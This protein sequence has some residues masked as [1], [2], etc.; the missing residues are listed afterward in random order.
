MGADTHQ[1]ARCP[2]MS[3]NNTNI[4]ANT[5]NWTANSVECL[6][7]DNR[8]A[9]L[10]TSGGR[11]KNVMFTR[12]KNHIFLSRL[13]RN[14]NTVVKARCS[15]SHVRKCWAC[16]KMDT[17]VEPGQ[18]AVHFMDMM[19]QF[20]D[21]LHDVYPECLKVIAY[22]L[23]FRTQLSSDREQLVEQGEEAMQMY[24]DAMHTWYTRCT[25]KDEGLLSEDIEFLHDLGMYHKWTAM[26]ADTKEAIWDYINHLNRFCCSRFIQREMPPAVMNAFT[27]LTRSYTDKIL[28]NELSLADLTP[29]SMTEQLVGML[30][31]S[32]VEELTR[33]SNTI[34]ENELDSASLLKILSGVTASVPGVENVDM[35]KV[36][37]VALEGSR[38]GGS[39]ASIMSAVTGMLGQ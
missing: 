6:E 22:R 26:E 15:V 13:E 23:A 21:A 39:A 11:K 24:H 37:E 7:S 29:E 32:E 4:A 9:V 38:G 12:E 20:L 36:L 35:E 27:S 18:I 30:S 31:E 33:Y 8:W 34:A 19:G 2:A 25:A 16:R 5:A 14:P 28:A 10:I 1:A 3:P 17:T